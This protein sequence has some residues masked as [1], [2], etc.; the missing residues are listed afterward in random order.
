MDRTSTLQ[1]A[2][3]QSFERRHQEVTSLEDEARRLEEKAQ[4]LRSDAA[5]KREGLEKTFGIKLDELN[6]ATPAQAAK[7]PDLTRKIRLA[8]EHLLSTKG[9][10]TSPEIREYLVAHH[11]VKGEVVTAKHLFDVFKQE[12]RRGRLRK[13]A[14]EDNKN[15]YF[16]AQSESATSNSEKP[17][18][19]EKQYSPKGM[20]LNVLRAIQQLEDTTKSRVVQRAIRETLKHQGVAVGEYH[21][22]LVSVTLRGLCKK[23]LLGYTKVAG[24]SEGE[25]HL[26]EA[27]RQELK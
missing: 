12:V 6:Q 20:P 11:A 19:P 9:S 23:K 22:S 1:E 4:K 7:E 16:R 14:T 25:Y 17:A 27:G 5:T 10:F 3:W 8:Q 24:A 13:E 18:R 15:R 26:T 2:V 21:A